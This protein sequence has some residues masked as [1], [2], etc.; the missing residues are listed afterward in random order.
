MLRPPR[1]TSRSPSPTMSLIKIHIQR[2]HDP[3]QFPRGM[4][5]G[6]VQQGLSEPERPVRPDAAGRRGIHRASHGLRRPIDSPGFK[7]IGYVPGGGRT[8]Y[9][10][11]KKTHDAFQERWTS[12][13]VAHHH[14][15]QDHRVVDTPQITVQRSFAIGDT[16]ESQKLIVRQRMHQ[17]RNG[18]PREHR[19][20]VAR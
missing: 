11:R 10:V 3:G 14:I 20:Y 8:P 16:I 13:A 17:D 4:P 12:H 15:L 6:A 19:G 18:T 5:T 7:I 1:L 9:V 2:G